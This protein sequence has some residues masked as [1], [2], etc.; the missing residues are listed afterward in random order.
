VNASGKIQPVEINLKGL[1]K[2]D[3]K[4][5]IVVIKGAKPEDTNTISEPKKIVPATFAIKG[6]GTTFSQKLAPY[7]VNILQLKIQ[8]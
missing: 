1:A 8:K 3:K 5:T 7:S 4:A 2:V 6:I